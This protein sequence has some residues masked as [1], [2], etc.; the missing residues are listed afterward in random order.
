MSQG[1]VLDARSIGDYQSCRRKFLLAH[2]YRKLRWRPKDLFDACL[3]SAV[4]RLSQKG[5]DGALLGSE[6]SAWFLSAA[7]N[8]GLDILNGNPYEIAKDY[9]AMLETILR[10]LARMSLLMVKDLPPV[11]LTPSI[12]WAFLSHADDS[13]TLHRW[14]SLDSWDRS[15]QVREAHSWAVIGDIVMARAPMVLHV[16]EIGRQIKGRRASA[17]ARAFKHPGLPNLKVRFR[18]TDG[19]SFQG[20]KPVYVADGASPDYDEWTEKM[21][22]EGASQSLVHHVTL[23]APTDAIADRAM[24]EILTEGLAMRRLVTEKMSSPWSTLPM[25]RNACDAYFPCPFQLVCYSPTVVDPQ[26]LGV[27]QARK[28][29]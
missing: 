20:W 2:D 18:R 1:I 25:A 27:Y 16:V 11:Q 15:D 24:T 21:W 26:V 5:G 6:A 10:A 8:P 23:E 17:W 29:E 28:E 3:R 9:C 13:G 14:I 7:A 12:S 22:E 4:V 19:Q